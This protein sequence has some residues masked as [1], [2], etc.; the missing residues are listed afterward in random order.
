MVSKYKA[1]GSMG[2]FIYTKLYNSCV[3]PV[4]NYGAGVWGYLQYNKADTI[5]NRAMRTFLGVH[6]FA[7]VLGLEGDMAWMKLQFKRWLEI[8]R[9]WNR[10]ILMRDDRVTKLIFEYDYSQ[11]LEGKKNWCYDVSNIL[12][13][14]ELETVFLNKEVCNLDTAEQILLRKQEESWRQN[15]QN[16]PK[17]RF[18]KLFKSSFDTENYVKFNLTASQRSVTAQIRLGILPLQIETGRFRNQKIEDRKCTVCNSGLVEDELHFMFEC[19]AYEQLRGQW[20]NFIISKCEDFIYLDIEGQL[21]Y[22]FET[23]HRRTSKYIQNCME[24]R[25]NVLYMS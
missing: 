21:K 2:Y 8:L 5:Q 12:S 3:L 16:K 17:L 7:P 15:I 4:M 11:A 20:L 19:N 6:R 1:S 23:V 9:L 25:K 10:L 22:V 14:L 24:V 18:Y 13:K